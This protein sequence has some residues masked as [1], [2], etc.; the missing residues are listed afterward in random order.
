MEFK[1]NGRKYETGKGEK[2]DADN[3]KVLISAGRTHFVNSSVRKAL[4]QAILPHGRSFVEYMEHISKKILYERCG[5][6]DD[7]FDVIKLHGRFQ[8]N[9]ANAPCVAGPSH[10]ADR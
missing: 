2:I 6:N 4:A 9:V 1:N 7:V 3:S 8:L 5:C 10:N